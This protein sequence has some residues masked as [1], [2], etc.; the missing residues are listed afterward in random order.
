MIKAVSLVLLFFLIC[1]VQP[2]IA[3]ESEGIR[4]VADAGSSRYVAQ[5]PIVLDGT[6][7]FDPDNSGL[8]SYTWRQITGPSV[9]TIDANTATPT[10]G[11]SMQPGTGRD[12]TPI[13][14][15]F[16]QTDVI[17]ECEFE[18]VVSDGE[19]ESLPSIVKVIIVPYFSGINMVLENEFFDPNKPTII[20]FGGGDGVNGLPVYAQPLWNSAVWSQRA[21][22][23]SFPDGYSADQDFAGWPTY[24]RLSDAIIVYLSLVA[25][26]CSHSIQT[27]GWSTGGLPAVRAATYLN[28]TYSDRRY[29]VNHVT[30]LDAA[31]PGA[32]VLINQFLASSVDGEQCWLDSYVSTSST[33]YSNIL[34]VGFEIND[35]SL[36]PD[37][38]GNSLTNDDITEFND[39]VVAGAYWSVIGPGK[40]LQLAC[41]SDATQ[42]VFNWYGSA[43]SGD[44]DFYDEADH[45]GKLPE[46]V[47]LVGPEDST[48]VDANGAVFS[49]E[50]SENAVGYQ[51]LF[52]SDPFRVMDYMIIS[53][54]LEP[55][56]D[57]IKSFPYEQTWWTVRVYD[58][59]GSTIYADPLCVYPEKVEAM[60]PGLIAHNMLRENIK[61]FLKGE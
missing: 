55:P 10:V 30:T 9:V 2:V 27:I 3:N 19:Y 23:L 35:H 31:A 60:G 34:N 41:T 14:G 39:G 5:D 25:P 42:Y 46:P 43:S 50:E 52:G 15:G 38:Y 58:A 37:W 33:F 1:F 11:G 54:T 29:A 49:C 21:N 48:F 22:L 7:S 36:P 57:V 20:Y 13:L 40:N 26:H 51:L 8:L 17:Q 6:G 4:P 18:L 28:Q 61:N 56:T 53:N 16:T 44:M 24:N 47:T 32:S 45:P 12:P 59:F